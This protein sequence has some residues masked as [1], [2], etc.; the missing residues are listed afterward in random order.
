MATR[1][2]SV[3]YEL[4]PRPELY[5]R[6]RSTLL[7]LAGA[8]LFCGLTYAGAGIRIP[9]EPV[10]IT[11]QTMFVLL[12]GAVIG[13]RG[14]LMSQSLYIGLGVVGVPLFAGSTAGLGV[15]AGP[16]GGYLLGFLLAPIA[17]ARLLARHDALWYTSL[18]F[19][20]GSLVILVLGVL[21]LTVFYT[22]SLQ[23]S[24]VIGFLPFIPGDLFKVVAATSIYRSYRALRERVR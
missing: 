21:H 9:L 13:A 14:G 12:S 10:P 16:T 4:S 2:K 15:L 24:F 1:S 20:L 22:K 7:G 17:V 8:I 6:S 19:F 18:V 11:M 23:Q 3:T 5:A